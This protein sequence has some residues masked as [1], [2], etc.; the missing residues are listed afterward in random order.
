MLK[1]QQ[2][3]DHG[4]GGVALR[5]TAEAALRDCADTPGLRRAEAKAL[6]LRSIDRLLSDDARCAAYEAA[7]AA[8]LGRGSR[9]AFVLGAGSLLPALLLARAG[10]VVCVVEP[11]AP[12]ADVVRRCAADNGLRVAV[13]P[14][15]VAALHGCG[16]GPDLLVSEAIDDGLLCE[17]LLPTIRHARHGP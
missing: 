11:L 16:G 7:I 12:L 17:G 2:E 14:N 5:T 15:M 13:L 3:R 10:A 9:T 8:A 6:L 1:F 4:G